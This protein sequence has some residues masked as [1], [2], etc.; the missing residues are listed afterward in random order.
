MGIKAGGSPPVFRAQAAVGP[1]CHLGPCTAVLRRVSSSGKEACHEVHG[2]LHAGVWVQNIRQRSVL[3][4]DF[5]GQS[6]CSDVFRGLLGL[7]T[8]LCCGSLGSAGCLGGE[9][10]SPGRRWLSRAWLLATHSGRRPR[11]PGRGSEGS[12]VQSL[13][14]GKTGRT[15]HVPFPRCCHPGQF[16]GAGGTQVRSR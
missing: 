14:L 5:L 9:A 3:V 10:W 4:N 11:V 1:G 13:T 7:S 12:A 2:G 15:K 6:L 8:H 16:S